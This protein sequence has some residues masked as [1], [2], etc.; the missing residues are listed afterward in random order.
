MKSTITCLKPEKDTHTYTFF[1][2]LLY[3]R[4]F[5]LVKSNLFILVWFSIF[6]WFFICCWNQLNL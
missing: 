5:A 4:G 1:I 6:I 3:M 2:Y